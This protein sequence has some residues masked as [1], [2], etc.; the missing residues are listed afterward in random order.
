MVYL[1]LSYRVTT[2]M[3]PVL[4]TLIKYYLNIVFMVVYS[5]KKCGELNYLTPHAFWNISDFGAKCEKCETINTITLDNGEL[6][7]KFS[8]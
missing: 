1:V 6:K 4:T 5:C 2:G 7:N 8:S 3:S